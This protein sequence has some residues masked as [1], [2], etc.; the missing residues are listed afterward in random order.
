[1]KIKFTQDYIGRETA[2]KQQQAGDEIE[3]AHQSA[4]EL[5]VFGVAVEV[6]V[7]KAAKPTK[8]E[9]VDNDENT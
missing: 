3:L 2:M 5:I 4:L 6:T 1:M 9:K 7:P 8:Q